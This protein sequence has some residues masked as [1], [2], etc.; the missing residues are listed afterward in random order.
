MIL[1]V[2]ILTGKCL[3][4]FDKKMPVFENICIFVKLANE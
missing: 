3:L 1:A 4:Y 2:K